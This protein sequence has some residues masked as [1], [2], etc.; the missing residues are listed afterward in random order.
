MFDKNATKQFKYHNNT[1]L[2]L[3]DLLSTNKYD[4]NPFLADIKGRLLEGEDVEN[5]KYNYRSLSAKQFDA[6][7]RILNDSRTTDNC[8]E[9]LEKNE[10]L[11]EGYKKRIFALIKYPFIS[12]GDGM[13]TQIVEEIMKNPH[14]ISR[15]QKNY[16]YLFTSVGNSLKFGDY[17]QVSDYQKWSHYQHFILDDP[18]KTK[19]RFVQRENLP[20]G[21]EYSLDVQ[22]LESYMIDATKRHVCNQQNTVL[23]GIFSGDWYQWFDILIFNLIGT[24]GKFI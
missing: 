13:M 21:L 3:F 22:K 19:D 10:K 5:N 11:T 7:I 20:K 23:G 9:V 17:P 4:G 1:K 15:E 8:I 24:F 18:N 6:V 14:E 2:E 12:R 16:I